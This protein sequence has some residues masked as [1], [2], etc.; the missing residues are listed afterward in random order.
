MSFGRVGDLYDVVDQLDGDAKASP[1][2]LD[3]V[4]ALLACGLVDA[5]DLFVAIPYEGHKGSGVAIVP[6]DHG[7]VSPVGRRMKRGARHHSL[8]QRPHEPQE[9]SREGSPRGAPVGIRGDALDRRSWGS[10]GQCEGAYDVPSD[11][12]DQ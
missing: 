1:E 4:Q 7:G 8:R 6:I 2:V 11:R 5:F 12:L 10:V 9:L 3:V